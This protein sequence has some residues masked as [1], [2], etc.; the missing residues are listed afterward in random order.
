MM[1]LISSG[2]AGFDVLARSRFL[3]IYPRRLE[4]MRTRFHV[5][6]RAGPQ[7]AFVLRKSPASISTV[8]LA[9]KTT[10]QKKEVIRDTGNVVGE[11]HWPWRAQLG[12]CNRE[13]DGDYVGAT[14]HSALL[15]VFAVP[16]TS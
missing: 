4:L 14:H 10:Q 3:D 1:L 7:V 9:L 2:C 13:G 15:R 6:P 11:F 12:E 16:V 8:L 5:L